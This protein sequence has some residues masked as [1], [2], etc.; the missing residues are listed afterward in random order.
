MD[1]YLADLYHARLKAGKT[2]TGFPWRFIHYGPYCREAIAAIEK[3]AAEGM[4]CK[5]TFD[6]FFGDEKEFHLFW[7]REEDAE[8]LGD[9]IHVGVIGQLQN[10]IKKYGEDTPHLLDY[11]YFNTEP[12]QEVRKGSMLDFSKCRK[13]EPIEKIE[14]KKLSPE[15]IKLAREKI[16][17]LSDGLTSARQLMLK[18][19]HEAEKYKDQ[20]YY[21]FLE[22]LD[23]GFFDAFFIEQ[24]SW[25][26]REGN[27]MRARNPGRMRSG[28]AAHISSVA[29]WVASSW[30]NSSSR[31]A[32]PARRIFM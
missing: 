5:D 25:S 22:L 20:A 13:P 4:I 26:G 17:K 19:E 24:M 27:F 1:L 30:A 9:R 12:M 18:K 21:Q 29:R 28:L 6:S 7:C 8:E 31:F 14:L 3:A 2:L 16:K 23:L 11:V 10:A 15:T 32:F